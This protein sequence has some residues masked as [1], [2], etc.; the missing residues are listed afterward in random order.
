MPRTELGIEPPEAK[1]AAAVARLAEF[2]QDICY[3]HQA[4]GVPREVVSILHRTYRTL[5]SA[6]IYY[7]GDNHVLVWDPPTPE[8]FRFRKVTK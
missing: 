2:L 6:V 3:Y 5:K 8:N 7:R 4:Q 1:A